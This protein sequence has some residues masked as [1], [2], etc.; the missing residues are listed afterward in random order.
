ML[1]R[2]A[3]LFIVL[4]MI[5]CAGSNLEPDN[6]GTQT[7]IKTTPP[8]AVDLRSSP[9]S[10]PP[11]SPSAPT[12]NGRAVQPCESSD[13]FPLAECT[14]NELAANPHPTA[15]PFLTAISPTAT[16]TAIPTRMISTDRPLLFVRDND[17][18]RAGIDG[19]NLEQLTHGE[20]LADWFK[21]NSLG[22][23]WWSGG[24]PPQLF[25]SPN[26]RW[27]AFTQ[28]GREIRLIDITNMELPRKVPLKEGAMIFVWSP[29][30]TIIAYSQP[31][32][33]Y[34]YDVNSNRVSFLN[35]NQGVNHV[36]S[37]DGRYLAYGCCFEESEPYDGGNL[38]QIQRFDLLS[39]EVDA[40][41][42]TWLRVA[43]GSPAICWDA[44]GNVGIEFENPIVCS[45]E[46]L[47]PFNLSPDQT[48][49]AI[50][51]VRDPDG[52]VYFQRL[53]MEDFDSDVILWERDFDLILR[54]VRWTPDGQHM[55]LTVSQEEQEFSN[56]AADDSLYRL[57]ATGQGELEL[58]LKNALLLEIVPQWMAN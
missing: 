32:G 55:L 33:N 30:S 19:Q 38:G 9:T 14:L 58:L 53:I 3:Q 13:S 36:W 6:A 11:S 57:P 24:F 54:S 45:N 39:S 44:A 16:P 10:D 2:I 56:G 49:I 35:D 20:M 22:D 21:T 48:R 17:L 5:G 23:R 8:P 27:I 46:R 51:S 31:S 50:L 40:V 1:T 15:T 43:S 4:V 28:T 18:W 42:E 41:G 25:I 26:G 7:P 34:L 29:D 12:D 52:E 37:P 47:Y